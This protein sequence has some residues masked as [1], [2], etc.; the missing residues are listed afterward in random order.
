MIKKT[1]AMQE[2]QIKIYFNK[3][4]VEWN[5]NY[6]RARTIICRICLKKY[7]F[8]NMEL[9]QIHSSNCK[10]LAEMNQSLGS[11]TKKLRKSKLECEIM[12]RKILLDTKTDKYAFFWFLVVF[13]LKKS[14]GNKNKLSFL[15]AITSIF[16]IFKD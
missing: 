1:K 8:D 5:K 10:E 12:K 16:P 6:N 14:L 2:Q 15:L 9:M 13:F 4:V 3:K 11:L 7:T